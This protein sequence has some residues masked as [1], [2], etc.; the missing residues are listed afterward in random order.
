MPSKMSVSDSGGVVRVG[1]SVCVGCPFDEVGTGVGVACCI[2]DPPETG[3]IV[4]TKVGV[5]C[6]VGCAETTR[7]FAPIASLH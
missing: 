4:G 2:N 3:T 5:G 1:V 6:A 7:G